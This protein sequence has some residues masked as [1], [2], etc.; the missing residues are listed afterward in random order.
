MA[1]VRSGSLGVDVVPF[2]FFYGLREDFGIGKPPLLELAHMNIEH[3]QSASDQ[4][5]ILHVARVPLLFARGF[6]ATDKIVVGSKA[7]TV[8]EDAK[9]ELKFVEHSGAAIESGRQSI[10][11]LEDRMRQVGA[12]LLTERQ[13]ELTATEVNSRDEDNRSIMQKISEEFEAG[14]ESCLA[15]MALWA[16]D[17]TADPKVELHKGFM[18]L[19]RP[20]PAV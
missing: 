1:A 3:W 5:N 10:R 12:E 7:A 8:A 18:R 9:A 4:Q 13:G 14:F 16:G 11:D 20:S 2:V 15:L 19:K 6:G 17:K